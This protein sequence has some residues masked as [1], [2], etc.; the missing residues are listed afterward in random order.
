MLDAPDARALAGF[1]A[2]LLGWQVVSDDP[3][4]VVVAAPSGVG[5]LAVRR[6]PGY[7]T[8]PGPPGSGV[9]HVAARLEI[10]VEDLE[11][12]CAEAERMGARLADRQV[13]E[14]VREMA[15]PVG[16]VFC[17]YRDG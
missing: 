14:S 13:R 2:E 12:A 10:E 5:Y 11:T 8:P 6:D 15:D 17:L 9:P 4:H 16:H 3:D 7:V 1:Y